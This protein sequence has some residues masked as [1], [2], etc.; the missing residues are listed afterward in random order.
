[1]YCIGL[2][3]LEAVG[4]SPVFYRREYRYSRRALARRFE[5][6]SGPPGRRERYC[7]D[8]VLLSL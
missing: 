6:H 5:P 1:M 8:V 7:G 4:N 2:E 3:R